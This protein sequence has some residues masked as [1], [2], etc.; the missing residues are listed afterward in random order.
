MEAALNSVDEMIRGI[1]TRYAN[2]S[3]DN[4]VRFGHSNVEI[5]HGVVTIYQDNEE[6]TAKVTDILRR[7]FRVHETSE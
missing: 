6:D 1:L 3:A 7:Y 2:E 4:N 5:E